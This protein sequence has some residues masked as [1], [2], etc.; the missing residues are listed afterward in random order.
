MKGTQLN[1]WI[2]GDLKVALAERAKR[3]GK[4]LTDLVEG[5]LQQDVARERGEIIEQQAL[6]VIRDIVQSELRKMGSQLRTDLRED[7]QLE[8]VESIKTM[9]RT[10]DNRLAALIVRTVRDGH[11][12]RRLLFALTAKLVSAAFAQEAYENAKEK[13]G[14]EL[15][16]RSTKREVTE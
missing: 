3:E 1:V 8:I 12:I 4:T 11:I 14:Q 2:D 9:T 15:A 13:A 10:S 5:I 7:M 16:A 6:P